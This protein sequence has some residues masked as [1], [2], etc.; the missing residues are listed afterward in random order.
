MS[1]GF[2]ARGG[3]MIATSAVVGSLT[4]PLIPGVVQKVQT[5]VSPPPETTT[6]N[7]L[8]RYLPEGTFLY[9]RATS[10][11][12]GLSSGSQMRFAHTDIQFP[13]F[14]AYR[15]D[16]V[17]NPN[18]SSETSSEGRKTFT[19]L[20]NA[21]AC[22]PGVYGGAVVIENL[23]SSMSAS[24][25][26]LALAKIEVDLNLIPEGKNAT[27]KWRGKPLF[28]RHRTQ[29]EIETEQAVDL[30]SLRDQQHD[31]DRVQKSEWLVLIGVCTHLGCVPV[32]NQGEF[33]GYYCPCHGSHYDS[34]GRIR[35][36]PAPLN[37]EIPFYEFLDETTLV[38]G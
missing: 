1:L 15:R 30:A 11:T 22:V 34:S 33:G 24:A 23:V 26:V 7:S 32:S 28:V 9:T 3:N 21:A 8:N 19:Y 29:E 36:G 18:Q 12:A 14:D 6:S 27:F 37:L 5:V 17:K 38:V 35:K 25:D 13:N 2:L 4:R 16:S 20:L 31:N 10:H